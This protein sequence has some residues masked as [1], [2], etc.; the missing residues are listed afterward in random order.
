[1]V[2]IA[3][4]GL[5]GSEAIGLEFPILRQIVCF[6]Y[7]SFIPGF[8]I[9]RLLRIHVDITEMLLYAVGLSIASVMFI[10]LF[11][12]TLYPRIGIT[13]PFSTPS[14][15]VTMFVATSILCILCYIRDKGS[16]EATCQTSR[17]VRLP[18]TLLLILL[19]LVSVIG[20]ELVNFY[21]S[22][23]LLLLLIV[24]IA[25]IVI[26]IAFGKAVPENLFPFTIFVISISL[27]YPM[28][29]LSPYVI[30]SDIA[31]ELHI[32]KIVEGNSL[33]N[34]ASPANAYNA[35]LSIT[36]LPTIFAR[37]LET[38]INW[39][40]KIL[41]PLFFSLVPVALYQLYKQEMS[42][43]FAFLSAFFFI[44]MPVF[45][46]VITG[47]ARQQ[48]AEL[49]LALLFL[50][51]LSKS[52]TA[53]RKAVLLSI[54]GASLAVSHYAVSYLFIFY[55]IVAWIGYK[56]LTKFK[57]ASGSQ[58][59][60]M[61]TKKIIGLE[62]ETP[63]S[64]NFVLLF[65]IMALAWYMFNANSAPF[66]ALIFAGHHIYSSIFTELAE[67][68][69]RDITILQLFGLVGFAHP[70]DQVQRVFFLATQFLIVVGLFRIFIRIVRKKEIELTSEYVAILVPGVVLIAL[71][72]ILPN[73]S[74]SWGMTRI[75]HISLFTLSPLALLGGEAF[76]RWFYNLFRFRKYRVPGSASAL[77]TILILL[78]IIPY[79]MTNT[80]FVHEVSGAP[81]RTLPLGINRMLES[82]QAEPD[83]CAYGGYL[84]AGE[85]QS[86]EW[87]AQLGPG[88][89]RIY[90]D[91]IHVVGN[92]PLV[93]YGMVS[94]KRIFTLTETTSKL[95]KDAYVYL[96]YM[97]VV[98][99]R[100]KKLIPETHGID[101]YSKK[102]IMHLLNDKGKIYSN[103]DSAVY[104]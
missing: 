41:Y 61:G 27:L 11:V 64:G 90:T 84:H 101:T 80:G 99:G 47:L 66:N 49:F 77:V 33:W 29:L 10:G 17:Q 36:I 89:S 97:N 86:A 95:S 62:S 94:P 13:D 19:P 65:S 5:I 1:M 79:F 28:T 68:G 18:P 55:L 82:E 39:I 81:P 85:V 96:G 2:Q 52:L 34:S 53:S 104:R 3:I 43:K 31:L 103:N 98:E 93:A 75:Y 42:N 22:N 72:I 57:V 38:D 73:L 78:V 9:L 102:K 59:A 60:D 100:F 87:L 88:N 74:K 26:M 30:G 12:N 16:F 40:Y 15:V 7:L 91:Y 69:A 71:A 83:R 8:I 14:L 4:L 32:A 6:I 63:A 76:F 51:M 46:N 45:F 50:A 54:F 23:T 21:H 24:L 44:S 56:A 58:P 48:I 20:T 67:P 37:F 92:I 35:M 25:V 70:L